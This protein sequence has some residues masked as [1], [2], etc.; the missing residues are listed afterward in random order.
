MTPLLWNSVRNSISFSENGPHDTQS[1][2]R[3]QISVACKGR[4]QV[5]KFCPHSPP[6]SGSLGVRK[7]FQNVNRNQFEPHTVVLL[8]AQ[9]VRFQNL[10][11]V[12]SYRV[13]ICFEIR[14]TLLP[15][16]EYGEFYKYILTRRLHLNEQ[17]Y[18]T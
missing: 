12:N 16:V 18:M 11:L 9:N 14:T 4:S 5:G 3:D 1:K 6:P 15:S 10:H 13:Q 17:F 8:N 7:S 2:R